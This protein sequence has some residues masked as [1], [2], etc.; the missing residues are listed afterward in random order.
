MGIKV[1]RSE[2]LSGE[3]DP[4]FVV[5]DE[6][7]GEVLDDAQGYGYKSAAGAHRSF[8]YKNM[9]KKKRAQRE[10][11]RSRVESWYR[12]YPELVERLEDAAFQSLK[13]GE[14]FTSKD[15]EAIVEDAGEKLPFSPSDLLR[16]W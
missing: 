13:C 15:A 8:G 16:Y 5:V 11:L 1:I 2:K 3:W 9:P 4:R 7:T 12:K 6:D 10:R 14:P